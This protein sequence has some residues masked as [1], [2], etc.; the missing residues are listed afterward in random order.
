LIRTDATAIAAVAV[1]VIAAWCFLEIA[2]EVAEG[3]TRR[4]D[5]WTI[6]VLRQPHG[7][8]GPQWLGEVMRDVTALGGI[9]V[10]VLVIGVAAGFLLINRAYH[11]VWV[12]LSASLGGL[13][14][15]VLLKGLFRRPRPDLVPH[16][17]DAGL[18]SFPSGH[19]MNSAT[20]YLT[21]GL[22]LA[23]VSSSRRLKAYLLAVAAL[24]TFLVGVSRVYLG[25]HY[26][27]DV[28][29]GWS[30]GG[31]WALLCWFVAGRLRRSGPREII[32]PI[33]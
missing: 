16:L 13:L 33:D 11:A 14:V 18:S 27:T 29:G 24:L 6:R 10:L 22:L 15:S 19:T 31:A 23:Q 12:V 7:A 20:V 2:D 21:L 3:S 17:V 28:L 8:S 1:T 32:G 5:E 25:V 30:A 4:L 26:P 9:T